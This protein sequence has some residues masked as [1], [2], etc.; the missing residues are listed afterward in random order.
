MKRIL[1]ITGQLNGGG[2][3][4]VLLDILHHFDYKRYEVTLCQII[5]GGTLADE[6][7]TEVKRISVWKGYTLGYKLAYRISNWLGMDYFLR[8]KLKS[9]IKDKYDLVISFLEGM[10]L[11]MHAI[12]N[13][14]AINVSWV[15]CD[16][17][18]D[19]YEAKQF[20]NGEEIYA[21]NKMDKIICVSSSAKV[22]FIQRF[23][24]VQ[25]PIDVI[26]N[27]IDTEKILSLA[28]KEDITYDKFT[29]VTVGRLCEQKCMDRIIRLA[30][31]FK[32]KEHSDIQFLIIGDGNLRKDLEKMAQELNVNDMVKFIGFMRNPF[33][34]VKRAN[35][36]L[37]C[38]GFEGFSLVICEAMCLGVPVIS[39]R[40]A[41]P[42][43]ILENN[44]Y[45]VLCNHDDPSIFD[46]VKQMIDEPDL[47]EHYA[48]QALIRAKSFNPKDTIT[49]IEKLIYFNDEND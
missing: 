8:R 4:R 28:S 17:L 19:P 6:V 39:T 25:T 15:H 33:P 11:K 48:K 13:P 1:F 10:P 35:L 22:A 34:Y 3:E 44:K 16:L 27:P 38:S 49:A 45:G 47:R 12:L 42:I 21:Y 37:S 31:K 24:N 14:N 30:A 32:S 41:G 26:Y 9:A 18:R 7:P 40:T 36:F 29:I 20:R 2:A 23:P 46:A 43:E 5:P